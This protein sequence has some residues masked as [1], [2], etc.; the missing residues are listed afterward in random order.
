MSVSGGLAA[1]GEGGATNSIPSIVL[2]Y[3]CAYFLPGVLQTL[4]S[5]A[6]FD[7]GERSE[8]NVG[9][10]PRFLGWVS[11]AGAVDGGGASRVISV[12][13]AV[14]VATVEKVAR[15]LTNL[16]FTSRRGR[17]EEV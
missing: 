17:L 11:E 2:A 3:I 9:V 14:W 5:Y 10:A 13:A 16:G 7:G 4:L 12:P 8:G 1:L 6:R 15:A